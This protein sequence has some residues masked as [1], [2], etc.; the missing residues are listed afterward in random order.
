MKQRYTRWLPLAAGL[1]LHVPAAQAQDRLNSPPDRAPQRFSPLPQPLLPLGAPALRHALPTASRTV[2]RARPMGPVRPPVRPSTPA[3][4]P[5]AEVRALAEGPV[6]EQWVARFDDSNAQGY[7][8]ATD[9]LA[10]DVAGNVY[11]TGYSFS[12]RG[13]Y[14]YATVKYSPTGQLLWEARYNGPS[15]GG[16]DVPVRLRMDV[17]GNVYVTG[18]SYGTASTGY[19]YATVK[20]DGASGEQLWAVRYTSEAGGQTPSSDDLAADLAVDNAGNVVVTGTTYGQQSSGYHYATVKYS[21]SG[22][23]QWA[24]QYGGPANAA[25]AARLALDR[26]GNVVVAG[27]AYASAAS[28]YATLQYS[29]TGQ[30]G[31]VATYAGPAGGYNLVRDLAV[32]NTGH[33]AVTG[34]SESGPSY[35]YATVRYTP[36]GQQL[37]AARYNGPGNGYD[38]ATAVAVDNDGAVAVTGYA[39][40]GGSN[41]DYVTI[42]YAAA[43]GQQ[44]WQNTYDGAANSYDEARDVVIDRES[45]VVVTGR[46]YNATGTSDYATVAYVG[47]T[48][49]PLWQVRSPQA[50]AGEAAATSLAV[51]ITGVIT[52]TGSAAGGSSSDYLTCKYTPTGQSLWQV[53][54]R[55]P[56]TQDR[57]SDVAVDAS[58]NV[59]VT[60]NRTVKYA[61]DGQ[62]L[63]TAPGGSQVAVNAAGQ[64]YVRGQGMIRKYAADGQLLWETPISGFSVGMGVD[65]AGNVVVAGNQESAFSTNYVT[66]KY[67]AATGQLLWEARYPGQITNGVVALAVDAAGNAYVAG[68]FLNGRTN[69]R[70]YATLKYSPQGQQLWVAFFAGQV[71]VQDQE[72]IGIAVDAVGNVSVTGSGASTSFPLDVDYMTVQY[73]PTGQQRWVS[74]YS[75]GV[76]EG[77]RATDLAVDA[78]GNVV[79]TGLT[80][81]VKYAVNGSPVWAA[82]HDATLLEYAARVATDALGNVVVTGSTRPNSSTGTDYATVS[83]A[84]ATGQVRWATRYNGPDN[85]ADRVTALAVTRT[86]AV[87]VAGTSFGNS[88][89]FDY[90]TIRYGQASE[91]P[92]NFVLAATQVGTVEAARSAHQV[93]VYPN[94]M[95]TQATVQFRAARD[96]AAQVLVYNQLGRQVASLYNGTVHQGQRYTL[97]LDGQQLAP[98]LY[99]CSLLVDGQRETVRLVINH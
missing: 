6:S 37:W 77:D 79:V 60:G 76:G 8:G 88:T 7:H 86:N 99:T 82:R 22:Q 94:P 98:G 67:A 41:W 19:D 12:P 45:R 81:T 21:T 36:T 32:D 93:A 14:D 44:T 29:P 92:V 49:L 96:G 74:A 15:G 84:A 5:P 57:V 73:A 10:A 91:A 43:S 64:V 1:L 23:L 66:G 65:A 30:Q 39:D 42:K 51:D 63:W 85:G 54:Y 89:G 61:A 40:T 83:Y 75:S 95:S 50:S 68:R 53:R 70:E 16:D 46:S 35:D 17:A 26:T 48:G 4:T 27:T 55:G 33:V 62:Q 18:Y 78:S 58:D 13:G 20:Y 71:G 52:V 34:T 38:E 2:D 11:V 3:A 25:S 28:T 72:P 24:R 31:W 90:A 97:A 69:R 87:V 56:I 9:V 59:Y 80:A 47:R